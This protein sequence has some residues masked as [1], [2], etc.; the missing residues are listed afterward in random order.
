MLEVE[1]LCVRIEKKE[2]LKDI[3]LRVQ[4][5]EWWMLC[6]PNG[7]GKTTLL[8]SLSGHV[9]SGGSIR[10]DGQ[11]RKAYSPREWAQKVGMLTQRNAAEYAFSVEE[12]VRLGR[13]AYGKGF[14]RGKD[15][16]GQEKVEE[17]LR[18]TGLTGLRDRSLLSLSGGELQRTFLSQV[19]AQDPKLLL[20]DEPA[21]HL[22]MPYQKKLFSLI[23]EWLSLP[24]RA[25][26]SVV[27]D[28]NLA[29]KF[30]THAMLLKDGKCV[31][32]GKKE[33]TLTRERLHRVYGMDVYAWMRDLAGEWFGDE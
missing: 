6:G 11:E 14:L 15:S 28:I 17:A 16:E 30:G 5:G 9:P 8:R 19:L 23:G 4:P 20:L 18:M 3:S 27:H 33:E 21:N 7:A 10:L 13:Y 24:G 31:C 32:A 25:V 29:K 12:T 22:D 26:V 2:I 1:N